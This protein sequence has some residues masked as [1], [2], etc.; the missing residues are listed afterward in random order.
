MDQLACNFGLKREN[1][2]SKRGLWVAQSVK[3]PTLDFGSGHDL[4]VVRSSLCWTPCSVGSL[5][6]ILTLPLPLPLP[7]LVVSLSL[8]MNK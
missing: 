6:E 4:R 7:L 1:K 2:E 3:H 5:L 8:K